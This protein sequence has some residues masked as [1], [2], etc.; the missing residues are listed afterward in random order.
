MSEFFKSEIVREELKAGNPILY[1]K[2]I[3]EFSDK[4]KKHSQVEAQVAA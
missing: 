3:K 2:I 1:K 4:E